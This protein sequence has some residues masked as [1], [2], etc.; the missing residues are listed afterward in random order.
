MNLFFWGRIKFTKICLRVD[1]WMHQKNVW[2]HI[3]PYYSLWLRKACCARHYFLGQ[4]KKSIWVPK[5]FLE[6]NRVC[7]INTMRT[8]F[9]SHYFKEKL[10]VSDTEVILASTRSR[11]S[12]KSWIIFCDFSSRASISQFNTSW[13]PIYS[14]GMHVLRGKIAQND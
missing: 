2:P 12:S 9:K 10:L 8:F 4:K 13:S 14:R 11:S 7:S 3:F 6:H 5:K 1:F